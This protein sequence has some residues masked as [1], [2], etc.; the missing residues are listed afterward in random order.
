MKLWKIVLIVLAATVVSCGI[1][2]TPP[3]PLSGPW[4]DV[5]STVK[6]DTLSY[7][8]LNWKMRNSFTFYGTTL[9]LRL[10]NRFRSI[11]LHCLLGSGIHLIHLKCTGIDITFGMT[12][13]L[14]I[15]ILTIIIQCQDITCTNNLVM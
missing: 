12:G 8:R 11:R 9:S 14:V 4:L 10:I 1:Q 5:P 6:I 15:L 13:L 7:T 3:P 2:R